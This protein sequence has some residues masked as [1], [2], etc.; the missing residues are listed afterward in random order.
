MVGTAFTFPVIDILSI[1][2]GCDLGCLPLPNINAFKY[3]G[4]IIFQNTV[5]HSATS[6]SLSMPPAQSD[7]AQ[8]DVPLALKDDVRRGPKSIFGRKHLTQDLEKF[9][10]CWSVPFGLAFLT[11]AY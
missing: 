9:R 11:S 5:K 4:Q 2:I 3:W 1:R 8:W 10:I 6:I 7:Y